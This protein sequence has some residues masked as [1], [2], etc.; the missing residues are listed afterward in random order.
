MTWK[1]AERLSSDHMTAAEAC[2]RPI[3]LLMLL[4]ALAEHGQAL[5][6]SQVLGMADLCAKQ[7]LAPPVLVMNLECA[8][9]LQPCLAWVTD[10]CWP[11]RQAAELVCAGIS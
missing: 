11:L 8:D 10:A 9:S 7:L 3:Q 5:L 4:H 6:P 1:V 2:S